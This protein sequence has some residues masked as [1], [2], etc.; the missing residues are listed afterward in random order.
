MRGLQEYPA[1]FLCISLV[2][3][4]CRNE[5]GSENN[6][7]KPPETKN[8]AASH[9]ASDSV[10]IQEALSNFKVHPGLNASRYPIPND[11]RLRVLLA[12]AKLLARD[13]VKVKNWAWAPWCDGTFST[14]QGEFIFELFLGGR[15]KLKCNEGEWRFF[16]FDPQPG[17]GG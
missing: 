2:T 12:G 1:I 9:P 10:A 16:S 13:D 8:V 14:T 3:A 11:T 5:L 4:G 7:S 17:G 15:G 6:R